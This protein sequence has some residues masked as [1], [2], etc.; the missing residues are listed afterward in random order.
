MGTGKFGTAAAVL[1]AL[2]SS[3]SCTCPTA[4]PEHAV[5]AAT[6]GREGGKIELAKGSSLVRLD[7]PPGAL[8]AETELT[9]AILS[10]R[11]PE[12]SGPTIEL[13]P[14]G[15]RFA[16]PV[17]ISVSG[18]DSATAGRAMHFATRLDSGKWEYLPTTS[19]APGVLS[20]TTMH[21]STFSIVS[22]C[23]VTGSGTTFS[24]TDCRWAAPTVT[25]SVPVE[26]SVSA[27]QVTVSLSLRRS[28]L[29]GS[30]DITLAGLRPNWTYYALRTS[31]PIPTPMAT[32]PNGQLAFTESLA[33]D[34]QISL[35]QN[36]GSFT[37]TPASCSQIGQWDSTTHHARPDSSGVKT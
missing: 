33:G 37:L 5:L 25:S 35:M 1:L 3:V 19:P 36:H 34:E 13:L 28:T 6:I 2:G 30:A 27:A 4:S 7:V 29:Y 11:L 22:P 20:G 15:T 10:E 8:L 24:L 32:D 17:N 31:S 26:L 21:F 12:A 14:H 9:L 18:R 16:I 23:F